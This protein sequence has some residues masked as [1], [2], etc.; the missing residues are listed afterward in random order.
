MG[1]CPVEPGHALEGDSSIAVAPRS[2]LPSWGSGCSLPSPGQLRPLGLVPTAALQPL[3]TPARLG[4][5]SLSRHAAPSSSRDP[6]VVFGSLPAVGAGGRVG[7]SSP[8]R[9]M[10]LGSTARSSLLSPPWPFPARGV[11][12]PSGVGQTHPSVTKLLC[13]TWRTSLWRWHL[14]VAG[15]ARGGRASLR[16]PAHHG[17]CCSLT[18]SFPVAPGWLP[19]PSLPRLWL[20][21]CGG[22][23]CHPSL[24]APALYLGA[25]G[26]HLGPSKG[27][28]PGGHREPSPGAPRGRMDRGTREQRCADMGVCVDPR[29]GCGPDAEAA[30]GA[31]RTGKKGPQCL[32]RM[33]L[34]HL[35]LE[36]EPAGPCMSSAHVAPRVPRAP[37]WAPFL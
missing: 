16:V 9:C 17:S 23:A 14:Q 27:G 33:R 35:S 37:E 28:P 8:L 31:D 20:G 30:K 11:K 7:A 6:T 3:P 1:Q 26:L 5:R 12:C 24:E 4:H 13:G 18:W 21:G 22:C 10:F 29:Y 36:L 25:G 2:L 15:R 19:V 32:A 34:P